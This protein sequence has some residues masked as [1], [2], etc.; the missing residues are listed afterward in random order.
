[1]RAETERLILRP[2]ED[3]DLDPFAALNSDPE[4]MRF[5][6]AMRTREETAALMDYT[7]AMLSESGMSFL[8]VEEKASGD[9]V[10]MV[11]LAPVK[12]PMPCAPTVE[13]GWRL[14]KHH[15]GKGYASEAAKA[16]L[17]YGFGT[18]A[19]PEIVAFTYVGNEPSRCVMQRL[20]MTRDTVDDFE[21]PNIVEGHTL[22]PHVLY[23]IKAA[24]FAR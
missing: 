4:V 16:W 5:F 12:P 17:A 22:R 1:M 6:P 8:A 10:G 21:H 19:L 9:L 14:A 13:I 18:M 3:R 23:R 11:G 24:A 20:G 15:W 2:W 7:R